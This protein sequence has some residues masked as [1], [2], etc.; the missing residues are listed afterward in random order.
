MNNDNLNLQFKNLVKQIKQQTLTHSIMLVSADDFALKKA[1]IELAKMMVCQNLTDRACG[2]CL[3]CKKVQHHN[4]ADVMIFP[5]E[6]S[7]I[8]TEEMLKIV[9]SVSTMPFESNKKIYILNNVSQINVTAQN[10][11][12]KTLEEPPKFVYFILNVNS[13]ANVL[14]TIKSRCTKVYLS[15][16]SHDE[17]KKELSNYNLQ[18][19]IVEDV[20]DFADGNM[21]MAEQ[22][23]HDD[24]FLD[25]VN[26]VF[27]IWL[28]LRHS[29][30]IAKYAGQLYKTKKDFNVV[31]QIFNTVLQRVIE[32]KSGNVQVV[33]RRNEIEKIANDFSF[34]ALAKISKNVTL[35][36]EK[37]Q[38]N[39]NFNMMIDIFLLS[40]LEVKS[41]C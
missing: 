10:K 18:P 25:K 33:N 28:N 8:A 14:P 23:V 31:M 39:C 12:L 34:E 38:R 3:P 26:F 7:V 21:A 40:F 9:D 20:V 37:F 16:F 32:F 13:E 41:K 2:F 6:K 11:L 19:N 36:N 17:I 27:D 15:G 5:E 4:H 30:L 22:F 1:S 24:E 29:S 35:L